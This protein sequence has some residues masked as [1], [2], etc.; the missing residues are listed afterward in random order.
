M[1]GRLTRCVAFKVFH[2]VMT[3]D[4]AY[5]PE[6]SR[7]IISTTTSAESDGSVSLCRCWHISRLMQPPDLARR[8]S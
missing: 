6:S 4:I 5:R 8:R 3:H 7:P 2:Q 1:Q